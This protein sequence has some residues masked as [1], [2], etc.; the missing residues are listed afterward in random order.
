M[1]TGGL[2]VIRDNLYYVGGVKQAAWGTAVT[3]STWFHRWLDGTDVIDGAQYGSEREGDTSPYVSLV[4]KTGQYWGFK[5]VEYARPQIIGYALQA[6]MGSGSDTYTAPTKA[7]TLSASVAAGALTFSTATDLGNVGTLALNFDPGYSNALYEIQTV[8]LVSRTGVGPYTYTLANG[9]AFKNAHANAAVI[10]SQ[11]LHKFTRQMAGYDPY[12]YEIGYGLSTTTTHGAFRFTDAVCMD[13]TISGE[14]G[15][16]WKLEH[17]WIAATGKLLTALSVPTYEGSNRVGAAGGPFVWYQGSQWNINGAATNN[18]ATIEQFSLQLKNTT[19][20]DDLQ[21]EALTPGYFLPG[22]FDA[23]G[24]MTVEFQSWQQYYDMYFGSPT[25]ANN[26][27]D[28]YHVGFESVDLICAPDAINT[29]EVNVPRINYTAAKLTPR[30]DGKPLKQP[31]SF[32]AS[33][34]EPGSSILD[35]V[36]LTL[37]NSNNSQY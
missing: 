11:S 34:P 8:N 24:S 4:W 10:N 9:A 32:T 28:D 15:K 37:G 30:L 25:A 31:L 16:P 26:A 6:L 17:N 3:P 19:A 2:A 20:W 7:G 21:S 22:N 14:R 13:L 35:A 5:I 18:A 33:K 23:S 12:T 36:V 27:T 1:A 29:F